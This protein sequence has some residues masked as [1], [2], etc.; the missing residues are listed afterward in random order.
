MQFVDEIADPK[1]PVIGAV[2]DY[3]EQYKSLWKLEG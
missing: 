2:P 1:S 3:K